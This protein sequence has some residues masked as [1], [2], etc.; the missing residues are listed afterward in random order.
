MLSFYDIFVRE[1]RK[2]YD[3]LK[4]G[5]LVQIILFFILLNFLK[6]YK[7]NFIT[8]ITFICFIYCFLH[9]ELPWGRIS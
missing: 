6:I 5:L 4:E 2:D 7:Y 1:T 8:E 3:T 9:Y